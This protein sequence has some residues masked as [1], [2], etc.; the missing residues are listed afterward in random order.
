M[1]SIAPAAIES[2][3]NTHPAVM[4]SCVFGV[5]DVVLGGFKDWLSWSRTFA[6][7]LMTSA[8]DSGEEVG[9]VIALKPGFSPKDVTPNH[10][11]EF[12]RPKMARF[13]I[14]GEI[15]LRRSRLPPP[16]K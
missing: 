5:P 2:V 1:N 15:D 9:A 3:I 16:F 6:G 12:L 7:L 4:Q 14:P 8:R 10:I 11:R 13:Q